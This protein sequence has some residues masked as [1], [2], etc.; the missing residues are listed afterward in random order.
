MDLTD[1]QNQGAFYNIGW[2]ESNNLQYYM[3]QHFLEKSDSP[4]HED[5]IFQ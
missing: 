1:E 3:K 4:I 2:Y 5:N